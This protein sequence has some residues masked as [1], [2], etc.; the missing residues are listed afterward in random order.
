MTKLEFQKWS[1]VIIPSGDFAIVKK[2]F[3]GIIYDAKQSCHA[4]S[5]PKQSQKCLTY[6]PLTSSPARRGQR[7]ASILLDSSCCTSLGTYGLLFIGSDFSLKNKN[8]TQIYVYPFLKD[9]CCR[10]HNSDFKPRGR[11]WTKEKFRTNDIWANKKNPF[12]QERNK[13]EE[14]ACLCPKMS[15]SVS[16]DLAEVTDITLGISQNLLPWE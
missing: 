14:R 13:K 16:E 6:T 11:A 2:L 5:I 9:V 8:K 3:T 4:G 1:K 15:H 10:L 7:G 12:V